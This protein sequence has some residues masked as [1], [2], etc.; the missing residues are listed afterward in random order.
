[1]PHTEIARRFPLSGKD[2][3][4]GNAYTAFQ[5]VEFILKEY[6]YRTDRTVR[7]LIQL[8]EA[9]ILALTQIRNDF[10][11]ESSSQALVELP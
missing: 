6:C 1:M 10:A 2:K 9:K 7:A 8:E 3:S 11:E 4:I 5:Y